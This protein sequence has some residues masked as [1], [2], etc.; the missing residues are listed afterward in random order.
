M[1]RLSSSCQSLTVLAQAARPK[2]EGI[3]RYRKETITIKRR[4]A[5]STTVVAIKAL[6]ISEDIL[7]EFDRDMRAPATSSYNINIHLP[8]QNGSQQV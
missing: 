7:D 8:E 6:V 5:V 4:L 3:E 2:E 1:V